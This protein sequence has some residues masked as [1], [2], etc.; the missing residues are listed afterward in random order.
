MPPV[1]FSRTPTPQHLPHWVP[2]SLEAA[3]AA[4]APVQRNGCRALWKAYSDPGLPP[5][6]GRIP[7]PIMG[8][9]LGDHFT[10]IYTNIAP[11]FDVL[12]FFCLCSS[13]IGSNPRP[14]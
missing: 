10:I 5:E 8:G 2:N 6:P 11:P 14:Y 13:H 1:F 3:A 12:S 4:A 7:T 9:R